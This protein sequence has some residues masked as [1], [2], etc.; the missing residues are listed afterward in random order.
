MDKPW[1]VI[2]AF[3]GIF[4]AGILVGGLVTLRW[5]KAFVQHRPMGEQYGPQLMHRLTKELELTPEEQAKV[6][7]IVT[8]ASEEL[9]ELRRTTQRSSATVLARMQADIAAVLNPVQKAKFEE[10]VKQQRERVRHFFE[11]R[12]RR[13][14]DRQPPSPPPQ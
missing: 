13:V 3:T 14:K 6:N 10:S 4:V 8:A 11:E 1:K 7:P 5:G 9:R 2:M 12:A